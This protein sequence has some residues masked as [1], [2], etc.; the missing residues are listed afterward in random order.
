MIKLYLK[1][2]KRVTHYHEAWAEENEII[3]HWGRIGTEG[4]TRKHPKAP[5]VSEAT[6]LRRMLLDARERGYKPI[7][8]DRH[9][10][11]IIEYAVKGMGSVKDI[12][13]RYALE[14]LMNGFL[15]WMG[16]GNCDG[17]SIGSGTME[18]CCYV[19][20]FDVAKKVIGRELRSTKF[21]NYTRIFD[22]G[23]G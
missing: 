13:K 14:E 1:D 21:K 8:A 12:E 15:G 11:L 18:V 4:R 20:D 2:G 10:T 5:G 16:L 9:K 17:G 6:Q 23:A 22:E 3:E 7:R 19:V